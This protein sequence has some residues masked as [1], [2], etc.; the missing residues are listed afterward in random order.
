[1]ELKG[2]GLA[3]EVIDEVL[4]GVDEEES[5]YR[6]AQKRGRTL[7]KEDHETFRRKLVAFLRRRGFSYE[8]IDHTVERLW[9]ELHLP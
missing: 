8:V 5:A 4:E 3:L 2:K 6:A 7:A 9:R 1:M